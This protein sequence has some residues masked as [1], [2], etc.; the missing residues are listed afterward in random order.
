MEPRHLLTAVGGEAGP[1]GNQLESQLP[2]LISSDG[3]ST[4]QGSV[5]LQSSGDGGNTGIA[6]V[7]IRLLDEVGRMVDQAVTDDQGNFEFQVVEAGIYALQEIQPRGYHDLKATAGTGGG[8][9]FSHNLIGEIRVANGESLADYRFWEQLGDSS[10]NE[11]SPP[12]L[13]LHG[14]PSAN[15]AGL[16]G[17][18]MMFEQQ[19]QPAS[20]TPAAPIIPQ[21]IDTIS[22]AVNQPSN[23]F[24]ASQAETISSGSDS[25]IPYVWQLS[26]LNAEVPLQVASAPSTTTLVST[27]QQSQGEFSILVETQAAHGERTSP[28]SDERVIVVAGDWNGDGHEELGIFFAGNWYLDL[29]G[30]GHWDAGDLWAQLGSEF[31]TPVTGD[32]DGDGRTDIGVF[33]PGVG[34]V[35]PTADSEASAPKTAAEKAKPYFTRKMLSTAEGRLQEDSVDRV[36]TFGQ[37]GDLPLVGD[38]NGDGTDTI[39][40]F[41]NG[42]WHLDVDGDGQ[43][44]EMDV[45]AQFGRAGD[46]PASFDWDRDG[47]D[48]LSVYRQGKWI[49]D[50]N[51]NHCCEPAEVDQAFEQ[52]RS[53]GNGSLTTATA[54]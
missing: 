37:Q 15:S 41:R 53:R 48:N 43:F 31:D 36:F 30:N 52:F 24:V 10:S 40:V 17:K 45:R 25:R 19:S 33:G 5:Q 42:Q 7:T 32:W 13:F 27:T 4:I 54:L 22:S 11:D 51:G 39:A 49:V 34:I 2:A 12:P 47:I 16:A 28:F 35:S 38:W 8:I 14:L 29:N 44:T 1:V 6:S 46:I 21:S 23:A 9:I 50:L 20:R 3:T 26:I 18:V